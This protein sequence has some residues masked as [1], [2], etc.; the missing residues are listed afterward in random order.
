LAARENAWTPTPKLRK[1]IRMSGPPSRGDSLMRAYLL[2]IAVGLMP[3]A[4]S[5]G[6]DPAAVLPKVLD[7]RVES[8]DQ[9]QIF[10]ALMCLYLGCS[11]FWAI[12]AF[13]PAWQRTAVTWGVFFMFSLAIGRTISL[14]VDGPASRLL[15]LYLALEIFGGVLGLI[16]LAY[17]RK[18]AG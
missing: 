3:I 17:S 5:Y 18:S 14:I 13:K 4:L 8:T 11:V 12:A 15:D 10:R 1:G 2:F 16:V 6:I 7:I 9:T